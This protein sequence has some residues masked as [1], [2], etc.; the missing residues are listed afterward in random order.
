M[1]LEWKLEITFRMEISLSYRQA[2]NGRGGNQLET[3]KRV[4][5]GARKNSKTE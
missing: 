1:D 4:D 2:F 3:Y 5:D